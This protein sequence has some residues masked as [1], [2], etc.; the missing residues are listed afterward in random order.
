M[1][2]GDTFVQLADGSFTIDPA[3]AGHYVA[4]YE[5]LCDRTEVA[6]LEEVTA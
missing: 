6:R 3:Q 5:R 1:R 4:L 2:R